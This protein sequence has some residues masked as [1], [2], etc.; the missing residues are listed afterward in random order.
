MARP[1]GGY[2]L[3]DGTRVPS[4]T[5][6][7]GRFKESGALIHWAAGQAA[8]YVINNLPAKPSRGDVVKV[9]ETAKSAYREVRDAAADAGTL[10]HA[11][12]EA[13]VK[14]DTEFKFVGDDAVVA[15]AKKSFG[16]FLEWA[17][18]THLEVTETEVSLVSEQHKFGGTLD[19]MLVRGKLSLGDWKT[20]NAIYAEYLCQLGGY[21][22]L[23]EENFPDRPIEGGFHL[24]RFDKSHGDFTHKWWSELDTAKRAFLLMRELYETDKELKK[25]AA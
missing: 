5:T 8:Q 1:A 7:L 12:V 14:R 18:Q 13:W 2:F 21:A 23:W 3:K 24:L 20:S 6:I 4:V 19:A 11:A 10:A 17:D 16:A 25:R 9:C 15:R 22:I